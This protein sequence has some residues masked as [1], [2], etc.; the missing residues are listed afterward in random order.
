[1]RKLLCILLAL[2]LALPLLGCQ[3]EED[4]ESPVKFYYRQGDIQYGAADGVIAHELREAAGHEDNVPYLLS[5]YL[6]GPKSG[7]LNRTF[8]KG[9]TLI[10]FE[11]DE[12]SANIVLSDFFSVLTGQDLSLACA[13]LTLTVSG[14]TGVHELTVRTES[15]LLD[16]N[17]S[18]TMNRSHIVLFDD[19]TEL[20]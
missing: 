2:A 1:M 18:I 4:L 3:Q 17:E 10:S 16:G 7:N 6:K 14:L 9:V 12:Y 15:T 8:P 5:L 20:S 11:A 13:C 19:S